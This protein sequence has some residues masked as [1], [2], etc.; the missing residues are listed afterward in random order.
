VLVER[1]VV[2]TTAPVVA[3]LDL[4]EDF[5]PMPGGLAP[6]DDKAAAAAA[7]AHTPVEHDDVDEDEAERHKSPLEI[8]IGVR[9][10]SLC[11]ECIANSKAPHM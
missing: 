5:K 3:E 8:H 2:R 10:G 7:P 4:P 6:A 11:V 9:C 1:R